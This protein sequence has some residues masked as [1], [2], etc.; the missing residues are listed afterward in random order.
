MIINFFLSIHVR[1]AIILPYIHDTRASVHLTVNPR[2]MQ[3]S[4]GFQTAGDTRLR[5]RV[6]LKAMESSAGP[7]DQAARRFKA[8]E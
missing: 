1:C 7:F 6:R 3:A 5:H 4:K 2:A 8:L